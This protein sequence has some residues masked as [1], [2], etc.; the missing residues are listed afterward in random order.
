MLDRNNFHSPSLESVEAVEKTARKYSQEYGKIQL[1][2]KQP[3]KMMFQTFQLIL[4]YL[5]DSGKLLIDKDGCIIWV[6][7]PD[8]IKNI[9]SNDVELR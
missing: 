1:W 3:K 9:L 6:F 2:E 4:G 7:D 5:E 8:G